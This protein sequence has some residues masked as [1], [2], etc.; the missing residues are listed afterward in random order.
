MKKEFITNSAKETLSLA[1]RLGGLITEGCVIAFK[2]DLGSGKTCFTT[3]L[4]K[5]LDYFGEANS[6]T[7]AIVNEYL[8]GRLPIYH[9]DMYRIADEDE[10]YSIGFYDYLDDDAVLAIEWSENIETALPLDTVFVTFS[11]QSENSRTIT[12]ECTEEKAF[13]KEL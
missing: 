7:F 9:F 8:G 4:A 6:P 11:N 5:G 2:G 13:L 10:L 12:I 3:G 1:M